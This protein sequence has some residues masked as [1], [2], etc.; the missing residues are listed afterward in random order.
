MCTGANKCTCISKTLSSLLCLRLLNLLIQSKHDSK[1]FVPESYRY[2]G[3]P[4]AI[5]DESARQTVSSL[6]ND[7]GRGAA[8]KTVNVVFRSVS[9]GEV[10]WVYKTRRE[11]NAEEERYDVAVDRSIEG[12]ETDRISRASPFDPFG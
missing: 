2:P 5:N 1:E 12:E 7:F 10:M 9:P 4:C 6:F 8:I 11:W 3:A